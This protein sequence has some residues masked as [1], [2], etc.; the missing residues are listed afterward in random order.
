LFSVIGVALVVFGVGY[1]LLGLAPTLLVAMPIVAVAHLGGGAQWM[2]S[3]YGLQKIVPDRIRGRIF[4]FD[5][6][7]ITLTFAISSLATGFLADR[8]GARPVATGLGVIGL[9]YAGV[10][11]W[12]TTDVRRAT[13]REGCGEPDPT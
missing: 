12:L 10:W 4:A 3:S 13:L 8:V 9:A 7:L 1:A 2:L 6:A 5:G 11:M